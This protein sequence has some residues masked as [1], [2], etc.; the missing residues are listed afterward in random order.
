MSCPSHLVPGFGC[1][2]CIKLD[3]NAWAVKTYE[4]WLKSYKPP[5]CKKCGG[6]T[7]SWG[8][9]LVNNKLTAEIGCIRLNE[10]QGYC[11]DADENFEVRIA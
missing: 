6:P 9:N 2:E 1:K 10:E 8:Y 3:R 5:K 7:K 11:P 4:L